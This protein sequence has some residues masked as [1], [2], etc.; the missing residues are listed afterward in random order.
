MSDIIIEGRNLS[1]INQS[2]FQTVGVRSGFYFI[3][4]D[5][6][7]LSVDQSVFKY[8]TL[9]IHNIRLG[10]G[11][12][13]DLFPKELI[14]HVTIEPWQGR[15]HYDKN[16]INDEFNTGLSFV[17]E[18]NGN[19]FDDISGDD[20]GGLTPAEIA[21]LMNTMSSPESPLFYSY[22]YTN[23]VYSA[24]GSRFKL[25]NFYS[26]LQNDNL[27]GLEER[28]SNVSIVKD[29][30]FPL[31]TYTEENKQYWEIQT[32]DPIS[33]NSQFSSTRM[34]TAQSKIIII[35]G[36]TE[37]KLIR[38]EEEQFSVDAFTFTERD[39]VVTPL[40]FYYDKELQKKLEKIDAKNLE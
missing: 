38:S 28:E 4:T 16:F 26:Q 2:N 32:S 30:R 6:A 10:D 14:K 24:D 21:A 27:L 39:G 29:D 17:K 33:R 36:D 11:Y 13:N 1:D 8:D 23:N 25:N 37:K 5:S 20:L 9:D 34:Q 19:I 12:D 15:L 22:F 18:F 35:D 3:T 31:G 40:F 7:D